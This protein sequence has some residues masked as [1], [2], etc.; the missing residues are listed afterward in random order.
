MGYPMD[1][2]T[3]S[4]YFEEAKNHY[5]IL[6]P[7][8]V[9]CN[10]KNLRHRVYLLQSKEP[11]SGIETLY[12]V[13]KEKITHVIGGGNA[14]NMFVK[15][16]EEI[17]PLEF[18]ILFESFCGE[19]VQTIPQQT[20]DEYSVLNADL[21]M[22]KGELPINLGTKLLKWDSTDWDIYNRV[23]YKPYI[24]FKKIAEEL[25]LH[26]TTVKKRFINHIVPETF[27][28][29]GYFEKGYLSYT[30]V[31]IQVRTDREQ[32]LFDIISRLS[33]SAY[34]LKVLDDW[35]FIL[36]YIIDVKILI[37]YFNTL[38]EQKRIKEYTYTICYDY[39]PR[40]E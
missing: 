4:K 12:S 29:S 19:C 37:K 13:N 20:C 14:F 21:P 28:L 32:G 36:V 5:I 18:P 38:L 23:A 6:D 3:I 33:S 10:Y 30:G 25:N 7:K 35:L 40:R 15:A 11:I 9:I 16:R 24:P 34:F 31:M 17:D 8:L 2:K 26:Q 39:L 1:R 22:K 27:W